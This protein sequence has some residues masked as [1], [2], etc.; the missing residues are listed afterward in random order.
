MGNECGYVMH[1]A[2]GPKCSKNKPKTTKQTLKLYDYGPKSLK[3]DDS[4][5]GEV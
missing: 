5:V 4:A 3:F 1:E 2:G